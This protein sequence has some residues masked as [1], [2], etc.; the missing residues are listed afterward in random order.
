MQGI[1]LAD[2][3]ENSEKSDSGHTSRFLAVKN[4]SRVLNI[5]DSERNL[6][7]QNPMMKRKS[8]ISDTSLDTL[9]SSLR[10]FN[11][12]PVISDE[13]VNERVKGKS[14]NNKSTFE[15][16]PQN[17]HKTETPNP[18]FKLSQFCSLTT[19]QIRRMDKNISKAI[20]KSDTRLDKSK[21]SEFSKDSERGVVETLPNPAGQ[22]DIVSN[23]K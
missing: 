17:I 15:F 19:D 8:R 18:G 11:I 23:K 12:L 20:K 6:L 21:D 4:S 14:R 22:G 9:E 1:T 13:Q 10:K 3:T 7:P 2:Q 16:A 5:Y